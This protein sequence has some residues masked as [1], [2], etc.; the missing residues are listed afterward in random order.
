MVSLVSPEECSVEWQMRKRMRTP[1]KIFTRALQAGTLLMIFGKAPVEAGKTKTQPLLPE[2]D[3]KTVL[4][5]QPIIV[6]NAV[7]DMRGKT[8]SGR[9]RESQREDGEPLFILKNNA[10]LKNGRIIRSA[11]GV[12]F[13]GINSRVENVEFP[14]VYE[15]AIS[16]RSAKCRKAVGRKR[17]R[18]IGCTFSKFEDKAV[19]VNAGEL[20]VRGC[21]F[22]NGV[23]SI[24]QNGRSNE[25]LVLHVYDC[26]FRN[27]HSMAK[28]DG[29]NPRSRVYRA[30]NLGQNVND[31]EW[32]IA[33]KTQL[34]D[35][36][37]Y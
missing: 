18:I 28:A 27:T 11:E 32:E 30:G 19:Q 26:T 7:F 34:I 14:D 1:A 17:N 23:T 16:T 13:R 22:T 5:R 12:W 10:V 15:D 2:R 24:R 6:D 29:K 37:K 31:P 8:Y 4:V 3:R 33:G 36:R 21:R 35:Q 9:D 20:E 25:P